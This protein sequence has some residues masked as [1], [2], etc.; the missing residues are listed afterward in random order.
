M[1]THTASLRACALFDRIS[2]ED[3]EKLLHCLR[4][5]K[6][7]FAKNAFIFRAGDPVRSVYIILS[8][9]VHIIDEDFWGN[10][11][12]IETMHASHIFGEAYAFSGA[13]RHIVGVMAAEDIVVL[14]IDPERLLETC[15]DVCQCHAELVKNTTYI[16]A[17]K[18]VRLTQKLGHV[19]RRSTREKLLSYLS[20]CAQSQGSSAFTIPFSRQELADYLSVD[21]SALS[22]ELSKMC[23][24]GMLRYHKNHF[25]L[26]Q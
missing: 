20:H 4:A 5:Q 18:I 8:G 12:I 17:E 13:P 24:A 6:K 1:D 21:R 23:S 19:I 10:R 2:A 3:T 25:E 9:S 22:H 14:T 26:L 16:L 15:P 11:S 7:A